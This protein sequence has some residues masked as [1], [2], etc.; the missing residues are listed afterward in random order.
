MNYYCCF[1]L[2]VMGMSTHESPYLV[3]L[4]LLLTTTTLVYVVL[5]AVAVVSTFYA[6]LHCLRVRNLRE[7]LYEIEP[8][9]QV[10]F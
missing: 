7:L 4:L 5:I 3:N 9:R 10:T 6:Y 1:V 8:L 2:W